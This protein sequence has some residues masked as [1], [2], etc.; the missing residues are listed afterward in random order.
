MIIRA[1]IRQF[2]CRHMM[3]RCDVVKG[4]A[5]GIWRMVI[6]LKNHHRILFSA[7]VVGARHL[8]DGL[9]RHTKSLIP[10]GAHSVLSFY[11]VSDTRR[12]MDDRK[13]PTINGI[14]TTDKRGLWQHALTTKMPASSRFTCYLF[15]LN[16]YYHIF[17][18]LYLSHACSDSQTAKKK[19][20]RDR[21]SIRFFLVHRFHMV[22]LKRTGQWRR[23][24]TH[25]NSLRYP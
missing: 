10:F 5:I 14:T 17:L 11:R 9:M 7:S 20:S 13:G 23:R 4:M 6:Q 1:D 8:L 18:R 2:I 3:S 16:F 22:E 19:Y 24:A 12:G 15:S 25:G 21:S